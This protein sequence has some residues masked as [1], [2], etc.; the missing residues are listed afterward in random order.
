MAKLAARLAYEIG[1]TADAG[2]CHDCRDDHIWQTR[3]G[4]ED[5]N[6]ISRDR[7]I[8]DSAIVQSR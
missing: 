6:S 2:A 7:Y 4:A 5:A 1:A 3:S 8:V